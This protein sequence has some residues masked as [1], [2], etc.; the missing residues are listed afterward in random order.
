VPIATQNSVVLL[1][2]VLL[3]PRKGAAAVL[4]FLVQGAL[5]WPVFAGGIG[6]AAV[7]LGPRGGYLIGYLVA[8]YAVGA[9]IEKAQ[10]KTAAKTFL[11]LAAG[12]GII[13]VLGAGYL[14]LFVGA[15][16]ALFLGVAPFILGD[17]LKTLCGMKILNWIS[18]LSK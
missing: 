1:L 6:G 10:E 4:A 11:A 2:A 5:G 18:N 12:T 9:L 7:L 3:G 17:V 14:S 15:E 16:K 13:Y 8:A